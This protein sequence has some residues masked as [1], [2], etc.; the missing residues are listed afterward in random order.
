MSQAARE[1][2][3]NVPHEKLSQEVVADEAG[4]FY[5]YLSN[6]SQTG[7]E[8][9][10]DDFSIQ[11]LESYIVQQTDYYPYGLISKNWTRQGEKAT[12]DLFQGK[13]YDDL[14]KWYDFHARQYDAALGRW[15]GAD[16]QAGVM[17]YNSPYVAM[18]NNPVTY[19]D[20]DGECPI[21]VGALIGLVSNGVTNAINGDKFF[22]GGLKAALFGA[23]GGGISHGIGQ[24]A[25]GLADLGWSQLGVG[26]FQIGAHAL[27]SGGISAAQGG[28]FVH[29]IAAGGISSGVSSGI[30]ALGGNG[31]IQWI[32]GGLSG[33]IGSLIAGGNFLQ[34]ASQGLIVGGLNHAAD[35]IQYGL[36][37][38]LLVKL[39]R[40]EGICNPCSSYEIG[41]LFE[42]IVAEHLIKSGATVT[43]GTTL[44]TII[45]NTI[46]DFF[47]SLDGSK[48]GNKYA[49]GGIVEAKAKNSG[50]T[51]SIS[52]QNYQILK[53]LL[54]ARTLWGVNNKGGTHTIVTTSGVNISRTIPNAA[55][56]LN[57]KN[58][59]YYSVYTGKVSFKN[60]GF[61]KHY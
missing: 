38:E 40:K 20:P 31:L 45:G 58:H 15:F 37:K 18:M 56:S 24:L 32:G 55:K 35:A 10:F 36:S 19:T 13:T 34:G 5:I 41:G 39:A 14:T 6:D 11:T 44:K 17:P 2:G 23:I 22:K 25:Q 21:C 1:D 42:T 4:Y 28:K 9:F 57:I 27:S 26:A 53:Q 49:F 47:V 43:P 52:S 8:A 7:S 50:S 33:G 46:P 59:H 3:T 60:I 51:L 48:T 61:R 30:S 16:P 12:K 29:G 54:G